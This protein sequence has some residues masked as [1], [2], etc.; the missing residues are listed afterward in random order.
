MPIAPRVKCTATNE[1][2]LSGSQSKTVSDG[3]WPPAAG[4]GQLLESTPSAMKGSFV[5]PQLAITLLLAFWRLFSSTLLPSGPMTQPN[6]PNSLDGQ[7]RIKVGSPLLVRPCP[8]S[9]LPSGTPFFQ[10]HRDDGFVGNRLTRLGIRKCR[11]YHEVR[12]TGVDVQVAGLPECNARSGHLHL[13]C[14]RFI[15][16]VP[17]SACS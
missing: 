9:D 12:V 10:G 11:W 14:K 4:C 5:A 7:T 17:T 8:T 6:L 15:V 1:R 16:F 3:S 2:Q 13:S